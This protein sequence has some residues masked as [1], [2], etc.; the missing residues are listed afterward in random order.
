MYATATP[1][2]RRWTS[3]LAVVALS[4]A[5]LVG[6]TIIAAPLAAADTPT[7]PGPV[8]DPPPSVVTADV[9]PTVQIDGVVWSQQIVGNTVYAAGSFANARP[10]GA[11]AGTNQTPRSNLLAYNLQTG[12]LITTFAPNLNAEAKVVTV[13]PDGSRIYIGGSFTTVN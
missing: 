11:A 12:A 1:T 10:A 5:G 2:R 4:V 6:T 8:L 13:S 3:V 9:L 7:G